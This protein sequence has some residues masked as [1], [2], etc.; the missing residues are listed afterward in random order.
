MTPAGAAISFSGVWFSYG[1]EPVLEDVTTTVPAGK[2]TGVVGPNG[3]GKTTFVRLA[4]GLL[5]PDR[6]EV[7]VL[8][9]APEQARH[10]IGYVPQ[11]FSFD[12]QFPVSVNEV[13]LTGR[14]GRG[15]RWA[16]YRR[17]DRERV[18]AAL[19]E[20]EL[21]GLG[22]RPL[23]T[24]SGGQRQRALI[25]R[26]LVVDPELLLLDEPT[27]NV[28]PVTQR[29]LYTLLHRLAQRLTVVMVTHDMNLVS[30]G[31]DRVLCINRRVA[32]HPTDALP[33]DGLFEHGGPHLR[34]V[35]HDR[36]VD[37]EEAR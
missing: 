17:A 23:S 13:L 8:E 10:L 2:I 15:G 29:E 20:V 21:E 12:P 6:G 25:A 27:A 3:G 14:L 22:H 18:A 30:E 16:F 33:Q 28:D 4:L 5:K 19:S 35:R 32:V 36:H 11:H 1:G 31:V 7:R 26:A 37:E 9:R 24:L 34:V